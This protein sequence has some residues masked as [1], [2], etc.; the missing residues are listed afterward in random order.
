MRASE[1]QKQ[2]R[3][4]LYLLLVALLLASCNRSDPEAARRAAVKA[5]LERLSQCAPT[6]TNNDKLKLA[7]AEI[8]HQPLET[9]VRLVAYATSEQV[10]FYLPVYLMSRGRWLIH[11]QERAYLLDES[12]REYKLKDRK[13]IDGQ[14]LPLEGKIVLKRGEAFEVKLSFPGLSE[15]ARLG[16]L[17]YGSTVI[18]FSLLHATR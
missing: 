2:T 15:D 18:P 11:E 7:V 1:K 12:C 6:A 10:D 13:S 4:V 14:P 17:I 3:R 9:S 8:T 5:T 16:A